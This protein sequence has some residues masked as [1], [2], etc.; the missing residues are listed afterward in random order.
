MNAI[1]A[2]AR[3]YAQLVLVVSAFSVT[4]AIRNR[5]GADHH[6]PIAAVVATPTPIV[7]TPTIGPATPAAPTATVIVRPT[8]TTPVLFATIKAASTTTP[9]PSARPPMPTATALATETATPSPSATPTA[10]PAPEATALPVLRPQLGSTSAYID[11][12]HTSPEV[13]TSYGP[14]QVK[15]EISGGRLTSVVFVQY[16]THNATS[17]NISQRVLPLLAERA[18]DR[19]DWEVDVISGATQTCVGFQRAMVLMLRTIEVS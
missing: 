9:A 18:M 16:P 5:I 17:D 13:R 6:S 7:H 4:V 2:S 19:Q 14:I 8:S 12:I 11:G 3:K 10:E 15:I 1:V